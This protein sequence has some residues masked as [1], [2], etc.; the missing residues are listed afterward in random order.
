MTSTSTK[1]HRV[2]ITG[3]LTTCSALH[4]GSGE[5]EPFQI[6]QKD[7]KLIDTEYSDICLDAQNKPYLPASSLRG[8]LLGAA[9]RLRVDEST[10][11][12][13]FGTAVTDRDTIKKEGMTS[14]LLAVYDGLF[15]SAPTFAQKPTQHQDSETSN[16]SIQK[17]LS[18]PFEGDEHERMLRTSVTLDPVLG[19]AESH[20]LFNEAVVPV[21]TKFTA[22][23]M[24]DSAT[25]EQLA[26]MLRLLQCWDGSVLSALGGGVGKGRGRVQWSTE[27][28]EVL[29]DVG[30]AAWLSKDYENL[31]DCYRKLTDL[32][33]LSQPPKVYHT[34]S[35]TLVP[36][37]SFLLHD[38]AYVKAKETAEDNQPDLAFSRLPDGRALIPATAVRGWLRGRTR[39]ILHTLGADKERANKLLDQLFGH[40]GKSSEENGQRGLLWFDDVVSDSL[41]ES[42]EQTFNAVDRFTGGVA[43][44]ALYT[45]QAARCQHLYGSISVL[46]STQPPA[47]ACGILLLIARDVLEGELCLGWGKSRGFGQFAV[48]LQLED[49]SVISTVEA[50]RGYFDREDVVKPWL[51]A[52]KAELA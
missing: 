7:G 35:F 25:E 49:G 45:V 21:F 29:D 43:K 26:I 24:L 16:V 34:L 32:P 18:S 38:P 13:L 14:G 19:V 37:G 46:Q 23:L 22:R 11:K 17:P 42:Y 8:F 20:K 52:L 10:Q 50:L 41:A 47:W 3:Q 27:K 44:T 1:Y 40:G 2:W 5:V 12:A 4:I 15:V 51:D 31:S 33:A 6:R 30:L 48:A 28:V 39:R 36:Q 9:R